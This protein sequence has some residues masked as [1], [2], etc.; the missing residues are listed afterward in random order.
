MYRMMTQHYAKIK[1]TPVVL[2]ITSFMKHKRAGWIIDVHTACDATVLTLSNM[3][4]DDALRVW[5]GLY[6]PA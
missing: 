1:H 6:V 3:Q 2:L 4:V 5:E